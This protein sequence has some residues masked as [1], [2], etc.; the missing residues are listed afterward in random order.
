MPVCLVQQRMCVGWGWASLPF[1]CGHLVL[2][3]GTQREGPGA[4]SACVGLSL[5]SAMV[6]MPR[7]D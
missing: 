2:S 1:R 6:M 5:S 7:P 3:L 4:G